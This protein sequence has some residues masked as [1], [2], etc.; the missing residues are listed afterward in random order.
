MSAGDVRTVCSID[1]QREREVF[2]IQPA[3]DVFE[4][5]IME[6]VWCADVAAPQCGRMTD[7]KGGHHVHAKRAFRGESGYSV[8]EV[9]AIPKAESAR[10][11]VDHNAVSGA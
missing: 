7:L 10:R 4:T 2:Y 8:T 3:L 6:R 11:G 9:L 5:M 1:V